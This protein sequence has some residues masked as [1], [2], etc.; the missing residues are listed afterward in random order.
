MLKISGQ[1]L[2][3]NIT[4]F[5]LY[6]K[7]LRHYYD[8]IAFITKCKALLSF[9]LPFGSIVLVS[10][11]C[12]LRFHYDCTM[13]ARVLYCVAIVTFLQGTCTLLLSVSFR[14]PL[15]SLYRYT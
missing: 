3:Y 10:Y 7:A 14:A 13:I 9:S 2:N 11:C 6:C 12:A 4:T 1:L 5:A 8:F 15:T